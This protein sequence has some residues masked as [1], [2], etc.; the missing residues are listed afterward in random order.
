MSKAEE[1]IKKLDDELKKLKER[2]SGLNSENNSNNNSNN[3]NN[4]NN[5]N[6]SAQPGGGV[7]DQEFE[8]LKNSLKDK[9]DVINKKLSNLQNESTNHGQ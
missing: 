2:K 6:N 4:A 7:S 8:D 3:A 5:A 1:H 9:I